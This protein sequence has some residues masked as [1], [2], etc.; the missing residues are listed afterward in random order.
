MKILVATH[1]QDKIREIRE[2][3]ASL[4]VTILSP[5]DF[6]DFPHVEEDGETLEDNAIK[7]G[8]ALAKLAN[9]PALADDTG[10]EVEALDGAPGVY[11]A[12]YS[13]P[14]ATYESNCTKLLQEM[15]GIPEEKRGAKFRTVLAFVEKENIKL[16]DGIVEGEIITERRGESGFGYDPVF[17]VPDRGMTLAEMSLQEKNEISHR[18]RALDKWVQYLKEE[19]GL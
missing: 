12:R 16:F 13:G 1:N 2:K 3:V 8:L 4:D 18:G 11:S 15:E 7:K 6:T 5:D 17:F 19:K 14:N 10:L 9:L